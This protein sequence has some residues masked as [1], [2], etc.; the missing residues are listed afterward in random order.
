MQEIVLTLY[1]FHWQSLNT[2]SQ[3]SREEEEPAPQQ[4][5]QEAEQGLIQSYLRSQAAPRV[6]SPHVGVSPHTPSPHFSRQSPVSTVCVCDAGSAYFVICA[7]LQSYVRQ[8]QRMAVDDET[9]QHLINV[10]VSYFFDICIFLLKC[11]L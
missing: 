4:T 11:V 9:A 2:L 1:M 10:S 7:I 6:R 8:R 3:I 5:L